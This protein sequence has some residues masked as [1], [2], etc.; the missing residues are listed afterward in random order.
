MPL[1]R[2]F[3]CSTILA[4]VIPLRYRRFGLPIL[5]KLARTGVKNCGIDSAGGRL[6]IADAGRRWLR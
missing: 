2:V 5:R 1:T 4:S 3:S 6:V